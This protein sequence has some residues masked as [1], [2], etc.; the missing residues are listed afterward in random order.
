MFF[1]FYEPPFG[2][3]E[4][5]R[6]GLVATL[7]GHQHKTREL[8]KTVG[9]LLGFPAHFG[10]NFDAFWD[11]LRDLPAEPKLVALVHRDVP[12]IPEDDL[13]T[14]LELLRDG[15]AYWRRHSGEHVFEVWF[16]E[17]CRAK[18]DALMKDVPEPDDEE[19]G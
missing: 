12:A 16:P 3:P 9:H 14:Y 13:S 2:A 10:R 7:S 11:C 8:L 5:H 1:Q 15:V 19:L 4:S 18:I 17:E 6:L